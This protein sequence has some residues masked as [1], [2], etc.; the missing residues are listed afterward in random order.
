TRTLLPHRAAIIGTTRD[1][2]TETLT[3]LVGGAPHHRLVEGTPLTGKTVFVF[4]GQGSQYP[5]MGLDLYTTHP[6]FAHHLRA[7]DTALQPH[8]GW[9]LLD[10]LHQHPNT[11]P[12]DRVDVIQPT[13]FALMTALARTWQHHGIHPHAVI[14]HSQGEIAAA[15]IAGALTLDDAAKIIAIRSKALHTLTNTGAMAAIPLPPHHITPHQHH[16]PD[17]HIAAYNSPHHTIISATPHTIDTLITHY[18]Q[19]NINARK[20]PVTYASHHPHTEQLR[21]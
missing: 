2:L 4:P 12:L 10:V 7:C 16:H 18:Q 14:G 1:E 6:T 15:H 13:L 9:S 17:L 11:P 3:A 20:L 8:T 21:T 5:H 19:H